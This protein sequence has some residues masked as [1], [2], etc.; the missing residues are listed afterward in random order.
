MLDQESQS[1]VRIDPHEFYGRFRELQKYLG[2]TDADAQRVRSLADI[3][4]PHLPM[5]IDDF[6]AQ[7]QKHP[8]AQKVITGGKEQVDRLKGTLA[9]WV[10]E[11]FGSAYDHQYVQ[12]RWQVGRKHA[13]IGLDQFYT[14]AA[15]GRMRKGLI[16]V[17]ARDWPGT[18]AELATSL[19]SL[20]MALDIDLTIIQDSYIDEHRD[21]RRPARPR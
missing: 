13:E 18:P 10:M 20:N 15:L 16:D 3:V 2:W 1:K 7:I 8:N 6:Y 9:I 14:N 17:V 12:R 19:S 5:L 21:I 4:E 11:L